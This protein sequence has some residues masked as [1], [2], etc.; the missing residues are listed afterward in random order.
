MSVHRPPQHGAQASLLSSLPCRDQ[1]P[2]SQHE[3]MVSCCAVCFP[4]GHTL[5]DTME[6]EKL[7]SLKL[8]LCLQTALLFSAKRNEKQ[9]KP[10]SLR[11]SHCKT[12]NLGAALLRLCHLYLPY[13]CICQKHNIAVFSFQ[14]NFFYYLK[15]PEIWVHKPTTS[16]LC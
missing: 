14:L 4:Q 1:Q 15:I 12:V 13:I 3:G 7:T 5:E 8:Q 2:S 16:S 6:Q 9:C 10:C 11:V